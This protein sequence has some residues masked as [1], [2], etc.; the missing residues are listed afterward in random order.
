MLLQPPISRNGGGGHLNKYSL[1]MQLRFGVAP[2]AIDDVIDEP[3][4]AVV[5]RGLLA[6]VAGTTSR[7]RSS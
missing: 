5:E 4:E 7:R 2:G 3:R 6:Q 1:T